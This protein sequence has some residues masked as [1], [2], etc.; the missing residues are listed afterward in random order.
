MR[1]E[2]EWVFSPFIACVWNALH[3][4]GEI[5]VRHIRF[6]GE[7]SQ[8][9]T[10]MTQRIPASAIAWG[11]LLLVLAVFLPVAVIHSQTLASASVTVLDPSGGV[12]P[13]ANV[14]LLSKAT[15]LQ[16]QTETDE[17][18]I[19][20]I[21]NVP[22]GDYELRVDSRGF[23]PAARALHLE[24]GQSASA[25]MTLAIE[26]AATTTTV[27]ASTEEEGIQPT[28]SQV[29][30]VINERQIVDLP[31]KGRN[32]IDFVMLTP[33][34]TLGNSTS[35]GSQAPFT[36]QTPK[37][38][39]GGVRESHSVFISLDGVDYTTGL[40]G[41]QRSSP[42][43]DWVQEF[44][45]VTSTYDSDVGRTLGGIVNT[46]TRSGTNDFHGG[47]YEF[48]RNNNLNAK[49]PLDSPGMDVLRLNQFGATLGGPIVKEKTF[50]FAGYEGQRRA[51]SP[52][53]S[54]FIGANIAGIN[55]TKRFFGFSPE[56][57]GSILIVNDY[58]K[59]IGKVDH[60]FSKSTLL[61]T[62]YIFSDERNPNTAGAPPGLGLPST[63]RN[64][65]IRDQSVASDLIHTFSPQLTSD[66][67]FQFA[68]RTFHLDPVGAGR[69][70]FMVIPNLV[71]SGGPVGSFTFY[72]ETRFQAGENMTR[73]FSRHTLKFGG[74]FHYIWNSTKSPMF[75]PAVSVF[76]PQ[77]YFGL[78]PFTQPTAVVLY[79]GM[80]RSLWGTQLPARGTNWQASL[81]PPPEFQAWDTASSANFNRQIYGLYIQDKWQP[82]S[83]LTL[84][85]GVRYDTETKPFG[86]RHWYEQ[87]WRDVQ[88]RVGFAYAFNDKTLV[89]GGFGIYIG[90]FNWSE[91]VGTS[92]AFGPITGYLNNPLVPQ[93]VNPTQTLVGLA[94]YGP[95]G[96]PFPSPAPG[97]GF[98]IPAA[99]AFANFAATGAY[100]APNQLIGFSHGFTTKHFPNPY[101]EN[102][103][104]Q[105]ERTLGRD[106]QIS[107]GYSYLHA[108]RLHYYGH[109]N[110]K[111]VGLLPDGKVQLAPADPN[112]G[113]SFLDSPD[114]KSLY[115]AGFV[116]LNKR[117]RSHYGITANYTWSRSIDN[118]T[119]IQYATGP[120]NYFARNQERAVSD[121]HVAHRFILTG[122]VDSPFRDPFGKDWSF[123]LTTTLQSPRYQ[124]VL[125]GFDTNGDGFPF[126]DRVGLLG[127]NTYAGDVL[128]NVDI[129]VQRDIPFELSQHQVKTTFSFEV[130]NLFNR[131]NVL[132]V[133]NIYAAGDLIGPVPH[134]FGDHVQGAVPSF[135][136]PRSVAD[137]RQLQ[138]SLR[139]SF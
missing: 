87:D 102:A 49:N 17:N 52:R 25:T 38:S 29:S 59:F 103:S 7:G 42:A 45:V 55:A 41:L 105:V 108:L 18:G 134:H 44:R 69:E 6:A 111:P 11:I 93:F 32:F 82:K 85:F 107:V 64:N 27:S 16:R 106:V 4:Q 68:R 114:A 35:V 39:F 96:L 54:T 120:Q 90:P 19:G 21:I 89:R 72:R 12:I 22:P 9:E 56:N 80:P 122:L 127:R 15:G 65:P 50:F 3:P 46:V 26:T 36:E 135:G 92:T 47:V 115:H 48:F 74:E 75:T 40:S 61:T 112:F 128:R 58:D 84:T 131:V 104:L 113:F 86:D 66:T 133:D 99:P 71:Q 88:P 2:E 28:K 94:E 97:G 31:I 78:A 30:E 53:F 137:M 34:V 118:Q 24:V 125:V 126:S 23:K 51:Q 110:A 10:Q 129:R 130:F 67:V 95:V 98:I 83:R 63:F 62:R 14:V 73:T 60:Q 136:S 121:N 76:T 43:Q 91:L 119:T 1:K 81:L 33:E 109:A 70:P 20:R 100:P 116:T 77:S 13:K 5:A 138:F 101:A 132:D 79:F 57:L 139:F 117:F 8:K 37:L 124:S 123:G